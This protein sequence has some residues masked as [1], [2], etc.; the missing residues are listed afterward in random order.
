MEPSPPVPTAVGPAPVEPAE[1]VPGTAAPDRRGRAVLLLTGLATALVMGG[2]VALALGGGG[3]EA[4][5]AP[6]GAGSL[7]GAGSPPLP[8]G[9]AAVPEAPPRLV[10]D[11]PESGVDFGR[12][13]Q[14]AS[15]EREVPFRNAGTGVLCLVQQGT[16]CGCVK[17]TYKDPTKTR[18]EPGE[19]GAVVLTLHTEGHQGV[20][21]KNFWIYTNELENPRHTWPVK[22]DISQ[23]V[24]VSAGHFAFG[25]HRR[26]ERATATL[27]L[28]SPKAD[29]EWTVTDVVV[30]KVGSQE[31]P[32]MPFEV[33]PVDDPNLRVVEVT[34]THPGREVE[35]PWSAPVTIRT[36]HPDRPEIPVMAYLDVVAPLMASHPVGVFGFVQA[37]VPKE[38]T[39]RVTATTPGTTFRLLEALVEG[40]GGA[41]PGPE[42]PGF[43]ATLL[44]DAKDGPQVRVAYDGKGRK[45]GQLEAT[46][47]LR[48]DLPE[49]KELRIPL[50]ATVPEKPRGAPPEPPAGR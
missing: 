39:I 34:V 50:R 13:K 23:G 48:T 17:L 30:G 2:L 35:G 7:P 5:P 1:P 38:L 12:V 4:P 33:K 22:A 28:T 46:L 20:Q 47:V 49:Q 9:C 26:G 24:I 42:G 43:T 8:P 31:P 32:A 16:P 37:G 44:A 3:A 21:S 45:P 15:I 40:P 25:R 11:L 6:V 18:Y 29:A 41:A 27:R 10:L 19:A 36:S 14:G